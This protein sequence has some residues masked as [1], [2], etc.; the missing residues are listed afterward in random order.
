[1]EYNYQIFD[2]DTPEEA[3]DF[4]KKSVGDE[5]LFLGMSGGKDSI[6][7]ADL[8]RKSGVK[9]EMF[10]SFTGLDAPEVIRFIRK[11]YPECKFLMPRQTFWR[12]LSVHTP[13]SDRLRW[14]CTSLKKES[15][16]KLPHT[17]RMMGIRA[18]ESSRRSNYGRINYFE[19][20]NHT[21]YYP[22][23]HWKEWQIWNHIETNNLPYP[24]LY[25]LGFD[26]IGCVICP[27]HSEVTGMVHAKYRKHWPKF[28]DR[29]ERGIT[30]LF[31]KR[32]GQG[33]EMFFDTPRQFLDA[34]YLDDSSRWYA[35]QKQIA[36]CLIGY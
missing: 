35:E 12:N 31:H 23:Y 17:K 28:F 25:D 10:Y 15:A 18:E 2:L 3:I 1:M 9:Y 21:H 29:W 36:E 30:E 24:V 6:V 11:N 20:L 14:C 32:Q 19:K 16:W 22:I 27:Y 7:S 8:V 34:W 13:P 26:R 33:K 4:I 5:T